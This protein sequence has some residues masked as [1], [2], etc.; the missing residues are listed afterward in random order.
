MCLVGEQTEK[1]LKRI[2]R[3]GVTLQHHPSPP[4]EISTG[5]VFPTYFVIRV[6]FVIFSDIQITK[7]NPDTFA[8]RVHGM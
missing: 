6:E 4:Q 7:H 1:Y 5:S 2:A 3:F 8:R